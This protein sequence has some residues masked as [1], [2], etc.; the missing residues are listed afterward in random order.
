[1]IN[2]SN[3][4]DEVLIRQYQEGNNNAFDILLDRHK[5]DVYSYILFHVHDEEKAN[6]FFQ[7]TFVKVIMTIQQGKYVESGQFSSWV[8]RIARNLIFDSFRKDRG[9][10]EISNDAVDGELFT[11]AEVLDDSI[12][13]RMYNQQTLLDV[14][15]L[16]MCLPQEQHDVI[17][18]R[19]YQE[20]SFKEI[21]E[22]TGVSINTALGR[23][24]YALQ[25]LRR[26]ADKRNISLSLY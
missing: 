22:M 21:A 9:I 1:M 15:R 16:M 24:R 25:N 5:D 8:I 11:K 18:M 4:A 23:M 7:E 26:M 17:Y 19:F 14:K 6:D 10:K 3:C 13:L 12:E 20:Y 2:L